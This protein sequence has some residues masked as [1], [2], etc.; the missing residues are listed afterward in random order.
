MAIV[1]YV[2]DSRLAETYYTS[3]VPLEPFVA[4]YRHV[5]PEEVSDDWIATKR[6]FLPETKH[7]AETEIETHLITSPD[8]NSLKSWLVA[9]IIWRDKRIGD[10]QLRSRTSDAFGQRELLLSNLLAEKIAGVTANARKIVDARLDLQNHQSLTQLSELV[11]TAD[12]LLDI[13][14]EFGRISTDLVKADRV[15]ISVPTD[16][17]HRVTNVLVY[18]PEITGFGLGSFSFPPNTG[19]L[20]WVTD[21][22]PYIVDN[23]ILANH[24]SS[25][26]S[27][28][29]AEDSNFLSTIV[30][31]V[32]WQG[33]SIAVITFRSR[34]KDN[35]GQFELNMSAAVANQVAGSIANYIASER[36]S[37][38]SRE[39]TALAKIG[40]I[41][42]SSHSLKE[43]FAQF[44][45]IVNELVPTDRLG[46]TI[47]EEGGN[48]PVGLMNSGIKLAD[49]APG[50]LPPT[51]GQ[52]SELI[53]REQHPIVIDENIP[54]AP[55]DVIVTNDLAKRAGLNSWLAAPL[56]WQEQLIGNLHFRSTEENAYGD[57]EIRLAEEISQQIAGAVANSLAF[58]KL[59]REAEVRS[60]LADIGKITSSNHDISVVAPQIADCCADVLQF[61]GIAIG[62][63]F[64]DRRVIRRIF[65]KGLG[66]PPIKDSE[67]SEFSIDQTATEQVIE[68]RK[69]FNTS[70][71]SKS[72]IDQYPRTAAAFDE[73][74]RSFLS[75]PL[76]SNDKAVGVLQLRSTNFNAYS[77]A[78]QV[79]AE[80]IAD[81]I[82]G[83]LANSMAI[84][85]IRL[86]AVALQ[87]A[88]S[89]IVITG[90]D[91]LIQW[92][93]DALA[94]HT[95]WSIDELIGKNPEIWDSR[96]P[97]QIPIE[98]DLKNA[99][100]NSRSWIG[101]HLNRRKDG[102]EFYE[103]LSITP[104]FDQSD[105]LTN[106][107]GIKLDISER[108][109]AE[110]SKQRI[111][112]V[113]SENRELQRIASTRNEFLST[114]SHELR[115]PLTTVSAFADI[116]FNSRSEN[117]TDRQRQHIELIRKSSR[118]LAALI[119]NLLDVSQAETGRMVLNKTQ[120]EIAE[121]VQEVTVSARAIVET[122]NQI[123]ELNNDVGEG[124]LTADRPR[125]IQILSNLITNASKFSE[126]GTTITLD[127]S[128]DGDHAVFV[129]TDRGS[130]ISQSDQVSIFTPF[131]RSTSV[132]YFVDGQ[133]L[134]LSV[135][136]SLVDLHD[137]D[138]SVDSKLNEGTSVTVSL[139]GAI[140]VFVHQ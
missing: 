87:S 73:G 41:V 128:T 48:T 93:N 57:R 127:V 61:D 22:V 55:T 94:A 136:Q 27:Q 9:P 105:E 7:T 37:N 10:L 81:Q 38:E 113:E 6:A 19:P 45:N 63:Y 83:T 23:E 76:V 74:I 140:T 90:A 134:G 89:P 24:E 91:G 60:T 78:D 11:S 132:D 47:L 102:T 112:D 15:S 50:Q 8:N 44:S 31:P 124:L 71:S 43:T 84:E 52:I 96:D 1:L 28:S 107:I 5:L 4:G 32:R 70:I 59:E 85:Q 49:L 77:S 54:N 100:Q 117:L 17:E 26:W 46:L 64:A 13:Q 126:D 36:Q 97:S 34:R 25:R 80:R 75:V 35:F 123:I 139:P 115:T 108:I 137:G 16:D 65:A 67:F 14:D 133:G 106:F 42:T 39:R 99:L 125:V 30:C 20:R 33:K 3:G 104:V 56:Y 21:E 58:E 98:E 92:G 95:G 110:Q 116:L 12:S 88:D 18:G 114:V 72:E 69:P 79:I 101:E 86:Q 121:L 120:F 135:V 66:F 131:F 29:I 119:N 51:K 122:R 109:L 82:A 103:Q 62:S 111:A 129:V 40:Q 118:Q 138:I 130:G 53:R 68:N 2:A